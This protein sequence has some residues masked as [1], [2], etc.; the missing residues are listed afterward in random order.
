MKVLLISVPEEEVGPRYITYHVKT[1]TFVIEDHDPGDECDAR[2]RTRVLLLSGPK[3][4]YEE[5]L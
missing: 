3:R 1:D 5:N 2:Y 4:L